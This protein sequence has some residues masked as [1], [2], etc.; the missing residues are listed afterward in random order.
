MDDPNN[1]TPKCSLQ[2]DSN[3]SPFKPPPHKSWGKFKTRNK[4]SHKVNMV[5]CD[6][7]NC[8]LLNYGH[9]CDC[10][11]FFEMDF[12]CKNKVK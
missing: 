3:Q 11:L 4:K 2:T 7:R 6:K 5:N 10:C 9:C 12:S 1:R 8:S